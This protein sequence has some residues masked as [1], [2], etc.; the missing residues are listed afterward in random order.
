MEM[1]LH[2]DARKADALLLERQRI[3]SAYR[4]GFAGLEGVHPLRLHPE[5]GHAW[6]LFVVLLDLERRSA[7]TSHRTGS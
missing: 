4:S 1:T 7:A 3:A 6:H 2:P 5:R